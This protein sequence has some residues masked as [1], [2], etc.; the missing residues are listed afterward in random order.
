MARRTIQAVIDAAAASFDPKQRFWKLA[1]F[2]ENGNPASVGGGTKGDKGDK[3][4]LGDPGAR[5]PAGLIGIGHALL[6]K[7]ASAQNAS[8][9]VLGDSTSDAS[10]EW[11]TLLAQ[12]FATTYPDLRVE[13]ATWG[14]G[15]TTWPS[16]T[17]IDAGSGSGGTLTIWNCS[18]GSKTTPYF[19][20][21][22]FD[23][24]IPSRD[25]DLVFINLGH[26]SGNAASADFWRD[27]L[28]ALTQSVARATPR[29]EIV[30]L[31][32]NPRTDAGAAVQ[33]ARRH[34]TMYVAK[35]CGYGVVDTYRR[36]FTNGAVDASLYV[37]QI[38]PNAAGEALITD[39]IA[40]HLIYDPL[41][42]PKAQLLSS[43]LVPVYNHLI[44]GDFASFA[45]PPALPSWTA[46]NA[47]LSKDASNYE[48]PNGYSVRAVAASAA[49]AH[50]EQSITG[51]AARAL[52]GEWVTL[53]ARLRVPSGA[54]ANVGRVHMRTTGGATNPSV[55]S[56]ALAQGQGDFKWV[57]S[58]I[59]VPKDAGTVVA[60]IYAENG[61]TGTGDISVDRAIL[62]K[63][64]LP[65]DLR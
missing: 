59:R 64:L 57:T 6:T 43:L 24:M 65:R 39:E 5:G 15:G 14:D 7:L 38:H 45:A 18:V 10:D 53:A 58:T 50:F 62:A 54:N 9:L 55:N 51:A 49:I 4:D 44:N 40:D 32:Q 2:D 27:E 17:V 46:T 48:G 36:F 21:P 41:N 3:G 22:N 60:R 25:P 34:V 23:T 63:G 1:L 37:D 16:T 8:I 26:N 52:R 11:P 28:L 13:I 56:N 19:L 33:A 12:W 31:T 30:L 29:S 61:V 47:T 35:M 20:A 42:N